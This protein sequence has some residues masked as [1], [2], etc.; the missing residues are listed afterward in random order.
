MPQSTRA[1]IEIRQLRCTTRSTPLVEGISAHVYA[2]VAKLAIRSGVDSELGGVVPDVIRGP[3]S[4]P[5]LPDSA[6]FATSP[7][8]PAPWTTLQHQLAKAH[9]LLQLLHS[10]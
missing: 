7:D 3:V 4:L 5:D 9:T 10:H 8:L 6:A 2:V 1:P